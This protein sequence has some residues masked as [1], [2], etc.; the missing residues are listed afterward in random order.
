MLTYFRKHSKGWLAY[1]AFGAIIV[2]F[3]LW[4]GSSYLTREA[5]MI[6]KIDRHI[7]SIEQFSKAYSDQ[8]K[9]YQERF[10]DALTPE[11]LKKLNLKHTVLDQIIDDDIIEADAKDMDIK[12][13]DSDLQQAISQFPA[14]NKEGRFD[15]N[16]YRRYLDYERLS[17]ADFEQKIRKNYLKQLFVSVLTE[18]VI[19]SRQEVFASYHYMN[20]TYDLSYIPVDSASFA[21]DVQISQDQTRSY[22]DTNKDRY[23]L[24]P[25][26]T[27]EAIEY[28]SA[29]YLATIQV[30]K[31]EAQDYYAS[32]KSEF[33]EPAKIHARHILFKIPE[34]AD[35][36]VLAQ[37]EQ[38]IKKVLDEAKAGKDFAA[39]A[40]QYSEDDQTAKK[41]GDM[42][43]LPR[44]GYPQSVGDVLESMK[45]G[46]VKGPVRSPLGIHILKL[47]SK[48]EAKAIP[49]EK[50]EATVTDSLRLERA[51]QAAH[52]EAEKAFTQLYEQSKPDIEA[53]AKAKGL[54]VK[55]IGPFYDGQDAGISMS[56][57]T[58][59][60]A[61]TF[62]VGELG[63]IASTP[64]G[65]LFYIVTK[66]EPSRIPDL[67]EVS[68]RVAADLKAQTAVANAKE[69]AKKLAVSSPEQLNAQNPLST[70][71][72][73]HATSAIP[74]LS[75]IPKLMDDVDS[76][77]TPMVFE[78]KGTSYVVWIKSRKTADI[79]A[80][81]KKQY[82]AIMKQ[83]LA[84]KREMALESYIEQAKK[85]HKIVMNEEK[86]NEG[87]AAGKGSPSPLD[88]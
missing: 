36:N 27:L 56:P 63:E 24:P 55:Q 86:L 50:V 9:I 48:E 66:K 65:Y 82:D 54:S 40:A 14:F 46:E 30:T 20:D 28:P 78:S 12:V 81:D 70:G 57:D 3:V 53:F 44:E 74:K 39:L 35:A 1:T 4:G 5:H 49:F 87:G 10:G 62:Q 64:V 6:A 77:R 83:L 25:R 68:D 73:T 31:N 16:L 26:I 23:K 7:I 58:L 21:K 42:G 37:K 59:K 60:K 76:L 45:P 33:S 71:D 61:F 85:R 19:V 72:F 80:L 17:P 43:T 8:L 38:L 22:Y 84:R 69:Y 51:K 34:G 15:E 18:N 52:D 32:H 79:K 29:N 41:G 88:Y 67:K 75:M 11:M 2:V 13:T 47:E